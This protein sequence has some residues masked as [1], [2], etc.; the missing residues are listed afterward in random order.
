MEITLSISDD[1]FQYYND[2]TPADEM[3]SS[4][5]CPASRTWLLE[6]AHPPKYLDKVKTIMKGLREGKK[7]KYEMWFKSESRASLSITYAAV[8]DDDEKPRSL[9]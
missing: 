5:H 1:I 3:I 8:H 2:N 6:F 4:G 7:D 9:S